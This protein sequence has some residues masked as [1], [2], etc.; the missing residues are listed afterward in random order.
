MAYRVSFSV[1]SASIRSNLR[2]EN[3]RYCVLYFTQKKKQTEKCGEA[4]VEHSSPFEYLI[5]IKGSRTG[6][7]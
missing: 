3:E 2:K 7:F 6:V 5:E 1:R 4:E